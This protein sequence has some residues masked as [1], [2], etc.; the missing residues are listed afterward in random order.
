MRFVSATGRCRWLRQLKMSRQ[1][2]QRL[3]RNFLAVQAFAFA[4]PR[5]PGRIGPFLRSP[6][7]VAHV[8]THSE[9]KPIGSAALVSAEPFLLRLHHVSTNQ[10]GKA[11][12]PA[13]VRASSHC[14]Q[15]RSDLE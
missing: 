13:T 11:F 1:A 5:V 14:S 8:F 3:H 2:A 9:A 12:T 10:S 6:F 7:F 15:S 4:C